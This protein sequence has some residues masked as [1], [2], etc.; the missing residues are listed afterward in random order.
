MFQSTTLEE[1]CA[2]R[3][4]LLSEWDEQL[5]KLSRQLK[6]LQIRSEISRELFHERW[7][8]AERLYEKAMDA[9]VLYQ[10][11]VN[12]HGC[13]TPRCAPVYTAFADTLSEQHLRQE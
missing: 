4:R 8:E 10:C 7:R 5:Q 9:R 11:H 3:W 2:E 12:H 6:R 1:P 13:G